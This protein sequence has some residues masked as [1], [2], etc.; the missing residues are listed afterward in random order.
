MLT[1]TCFILSL[2]LI[3]YCSA[4]LFVNETEVEAEDAP[5]I[6]TDARKQKFTH[7]Q[8]L[9]HALFAGYNKHLRPLRNPN[10]ALKVYINPSISGI[11]KADELDQSLKFFQWFPMIWRDE[12]LAWS[13]SKFGGLQFIM[14]PSNL[15]WLP[16]I[17]AFTTME[18]IETMPMEKTYARVDYEGN[19]TIVKHQFLTVR[20]QYHILLFP[21][22]VQQCRMPFGSWAYT[23]EQIELE[24]FESRL[25]QQIFEENSEW[26]IVS[27]TARKESVTYESFS[28]II[29]RTFQELHYDL[30]FKR[31]PTFY[32]YMIVVPCSIIVN[33]C[34]LGLFAPFNTN[35]DRQEKLTLGLTTLLTVAVLLHIV[36]GQMPKSAEG[37]PLLGKFILVELIVCATALAVSVLLMYGHRQVIKRRWVAPNFVRTYANYLKPHRV[38]EESSHLLEERSQVDLSEVQFNNS[39]KNDHQHTFTQITLLKTYIA[40]VTAM[41][42]QLLRFQEDTTLHEVWNIAFEWIDMI[43]LGTFL[44]VNLLL[45]Y[46]MFVMVPAA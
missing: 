39:P 11:I 7:E 8:R 36:S 40:H 42:K 17:F 6:T 28:T 37:L 3:N 32:I 9:Y 33:I 14:I 43:L 34:L 31:K 25:A 2:L 35:G 21:F 15:I 10:K 22:D 5:R 20:C 41:K 46:I 4:N 12:L 19:V 26:E 1:V 23:T 24:A 16:D 45:T 44:S 18:A 30:V 29:N 27:F 13:P 38:L